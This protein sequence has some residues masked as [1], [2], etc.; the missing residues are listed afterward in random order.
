MKVCVQVG[1]SLP[2]PPAA[3]ELR[4]RLLPWSERD[5]QAGGGLV[6]EGGEGRLGWA[7]PSGRRA[8]TVLSGRDGAQRHVAGSGPPS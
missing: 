3:K 2:L 4:Q 6:A 8:S 7:C 5:A 1:L